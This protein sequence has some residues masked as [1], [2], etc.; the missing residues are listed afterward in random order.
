VSPPVKLCRTT[1]R[2]HG[3]WLAMSWAH[4]RLAGDFDVHDPPAGP[5]AIRE[6]LDD[7]WPSKG[8]L[9]LATSYGLLTRLCGSR[10]A[11]S[12]AAA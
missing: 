3:L 4:R 6:H 7:Y 12:Q 1:M 5:V 8:C 11:R 2:S 10:R 9:L